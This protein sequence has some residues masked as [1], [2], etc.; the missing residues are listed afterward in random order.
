[1]IKVHLAE[2]QENFAQ[3]V[4]DYL[5]NGSFNSLL[6]VAG[7]GAGKTV[8]FGWVVEMLKKA[9]KKCLILTDR[10]SLFKTN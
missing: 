1:M 3:A 8:M 4:D 5:I 6:A 10:E 2:H 7:T 9:G